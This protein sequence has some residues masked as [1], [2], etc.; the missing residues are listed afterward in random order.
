MADKRSTRRIV[1]GRFVEVEKRFKEEVTSEDKASQEVLQE[2]RQVE[3]VI[4]LPLMEILSVIIGKMDIQ[5]QETINKLEEI[6]VKCDKIGDVADELKSNE[7][8]VQVLCVD[9]EELEENVNIENSFNIN[10]ESKI[11]DSVEEIRKKLKMI[12]KDNREDCYFVKDICLVGKLKE[13]SQLEEEVGKLIKDNPVF[14]KDYMNKKGVKDRMINELGFEISCFD[15]SQLKN[16]MRV[17]LRNRKGRIIRNNLG[18]KNILRKD[19]V[20]ML[21]K[22]IKGL[23]VR[24]WKSFRKKG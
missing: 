22:Q 10:E 17:R 2:V 6:Y 1:K 11:D 19:I 23:L 4:E 21:R 18:R 9:K 13:I 7:L 16:I 3:E 12:N 15:E 24:S 20:I 5:H 8:G 14:I